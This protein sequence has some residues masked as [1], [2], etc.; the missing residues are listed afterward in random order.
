MGTAEEEIKIWLKKRDAPS[1]AVSRHI[2]SPSIRSVCATAHWTKNSAPCTLPRARTNQMATTTLS[3][4]I[5]ATTDDLYALP[6]LE[7]ITAEYAWHVLHDS[8]EKCMRVAKN[9]LT[10]LADFVNIFCSDHKRE[11]EF[12]R[13]MNL[14]DT[15]NA[16]E[17][18][19]RAYLH[20]YLAA[21]CM[22][23]ETTP[24]GKTSAARCSVFEEYFE[25]PVKY[26]HDRSW[27]HLLTAERHGSA[28][29]V[30]MIAE[31][32]RALKMQGITVCGFYSALRRQDQEVPSA[33]SAILDGVSAIAKERTVHVD[34]VR[35]ATKW[36]E[37]LAACE[38]VRLVK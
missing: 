8:N 4:K 38:F 37:K 15:E 1:S 30:V 9:R 3:T 28:V 29:A 5:A 16:D 12:E 17:M 6:I 26:L 23:R 31:G 11:L 32:E 36:R 13:L 14:T 24:D 21:R 20:E 33:G 19:L 2:H 34:P 25:R 7:M 18:A 22:P 27:T 35:R 10:D